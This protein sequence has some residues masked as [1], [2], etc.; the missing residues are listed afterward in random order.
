MINIGLETYK[1]TTKTAF[2]QSGF[3]PFFLLATGYSALIMTLWAGIYTFGWN[4]PLKA[5]SSMIWHAHEMIYGYTMAV[6]AGFLL[7]A[8]RNWTKQQTADGS[9]LL[10]LVI[11]WIIGRTPPIT[12]A[13]AYFQAFGDFVFGFLFLLVIALPL[14]RSSLT[15]QWPVMLIL[16]LLWSINTVY[17]L[18]NFKWLPGN[19]RTTLYI[20]LNLVL[21]LVFIFSRRLIPNFI[22]S[23]LRLKTPVF[24]RP[25]LDKTIIPLFIA[26]SINEIFFQQDEAKVILS[27]IL[28]II[29]GLRLYDWFQK[30]IW[31]RHLIWSLYL[32]YV[33]LTIGFL[34]KILEYFIGTYPFISLHLFTVGGLS[35]V[36]LSMMARVSLGHTGRN[37]LEELQATRWLFWGLLLTI[38]FRIFLPWLFPQYYLYLVRTAMVFWI[39]TFLF[40]MFRFI[41]ILLRKR[42]DG[43]Y[44]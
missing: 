31:S 7:T 23:A 13:L 1:R 10:T 6:I 11:F 38:L 2:L 17:H 22:N 19:P 25:I 42:T 12:I 27:S 4:I 3:R 30:A 14:I 16:A 29:N 36:T 8:V 44:G 5:Q 41:G 20:S 26:F 39:L 43:L 40:F 21:T 9:L 32:S 34:F 33:F 35:L 15:K 24:N 28:L 18:Q 37:V